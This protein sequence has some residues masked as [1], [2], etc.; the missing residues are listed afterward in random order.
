MES[1]S[2]I[3]IYEPCGPNLVG[4]SGDKLRSD[5][6]NIMRRMPHHLVLDLTKIE[7]VD[8]S[9]LGVFVLISKLMSPNSNL[10][11]CGLGEKLSQV[12]ANNKMEKLMKLHRSIDDA[13]SSLPKNGEVNRVYTNNS[14]T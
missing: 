13:I 2:S 1:S 5:L 4:N 10:H 7:F 14:R 11:L 6:T 12:L 3:L 8:S 9:T